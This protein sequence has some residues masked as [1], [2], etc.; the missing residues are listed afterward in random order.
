MADNLNISPPDQR[1]TVESLEG[2][3]KSGRPLELKGKIRNVARLSKQ[4]K[5]VLSGLAAVLV[6]GILVGTLTAGN[7]TPKAASADNSGAD[8][9]GTVAPDV[10]PAKPAAN[11]FNAS[12]VAATTASADNK[13]TPRGNDPLNPSGAQTNGSAAALTPAQQYQAWLVQQHYKRLEG[14]IL[15]GDAAVTAEIGKGGAAGLMQTQTADTEDAGGGTQRLA[16]A[17]TAALK[18]IVNHPQAAQSPDLQNLLKTL[19]AGGAANGVGASADTGGGDGNGQAA[20][21]QFLADALK[22]SLDDG[23][24]PVLEQPR[25]SEHELFAGS[26][27]PAVLI[28]GIDSDL[29][30]VISAQVRQTVYDSL[31]PNVVLIPQGTKLIGQYSSAVAYGQHRVLAAWS[32]LIYPN[33]ATIDLEGM[34]AAD[35]QGR[36]GMADQVD[37]HYFKTFGSAILMSLLGVGAE[38]SQPQN[39]GAFNTPSAGAQAASALA[40]SLNQSGTLLLQKNLQI[41]PTIKVRPGYTFNVIVN[42]TMIL[43]PYQSR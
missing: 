22:S 10:T 16:D 2:P 39:S 20:N 4:S 25:A 33:G 9:V 37:N 11:P 6:G 21:K 38:L 14:Q 40:T 34:S 32:R 24:L 29:P 43:P 26:I 27:I 15:A 28:S 19:A 18:L 30:G 31:N 12:P 7:N 5:T 41:Q 1:P 3:G 36:S 23:Y 42:R 8:S 17:Q 13:L 35:R